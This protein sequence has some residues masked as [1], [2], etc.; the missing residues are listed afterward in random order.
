MALQGTCVTKVFSRFGTVGTALNSRAPDQAPDPILNSESSVYH[1]TASAA[2]RLITTLCL[3][4]VTLGARRSGPARAAPARPRG[5][6][7]GEHVADRAT[8]RRWP[9]LPEQLPA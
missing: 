7:R 9:A 4:C 1:L 5:Y 3:R 8:L 2:T 6:R